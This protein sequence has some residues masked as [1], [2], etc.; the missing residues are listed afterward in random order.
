AAG[1]AVAIRSR[2]RGARARWV[3]TAQRTAAQNLAGH[4]AASRSTRQRLKAL[5]ATLGLAETPR[6]LECFDISHSSG[7]ATVASCVVFGDDGPLKSQYRRFNI[8]EVAA[9]DDYAAMEQALQRRYR[10]LQQG[11]GQLP[12]VLFV[13]GGR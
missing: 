4:L 3:E 10:R 13:D 11:E 7:E 12:D 5:A 8:Q 9:G 1:R 6:R 2:P